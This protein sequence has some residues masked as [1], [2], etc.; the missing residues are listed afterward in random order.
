MKLN[1]S[2]GSIIAASLALI[3]VGIMIGF[4]VHGGF[5]GPDLEDRPGYV[6]YALEESDSITTNYG[7]RESSEG[8]KFV[9]VSYNIVNNSYDQGILLGPSFFDLECQGVTY[10]YSTYTFSYPG[11]VSG[12]GEILPSGSV[13]T[14]IVYQVPSNVNL[15]SISVIWDGYP[16]DLYFER[17]GAS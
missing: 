17:V 7:E 15:D 5:G 2:N 10:K 14:K 6:Q 8:Y 12:V 13:D 11:Y 9:V 1:A 4:D 16:E 3:I